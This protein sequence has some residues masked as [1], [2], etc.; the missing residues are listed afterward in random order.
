VLDSKL[1]F[2]VIKTLNLQPGFINSIVN[3]SNLFASG[4]DNGTI[5]IWDIDSY[6][7]LTTI[8]AEERNIGI[9]ALLPVEKANL[10]ISGSAK[11]LKVWH[12]KNVKNADF[13][14]QCVHCEYTNG[15]VSSLLLLPGRY[16]VSG[17]NFGYIKIYSLINFQCVKVFEEF[18]NPVKS[19]LLLRDNRL[20]ASTDSQ[21]MAWDY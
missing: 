4:S 8:N 13:S 10:L 5:N 20:V 19:M 12:L 15:G 18:R 17:G 1:D 21:I 14:A 7:W 16:F 3:L 11:R 6:D 9:K 2:K